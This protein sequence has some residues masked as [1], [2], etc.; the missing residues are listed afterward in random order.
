MTRNNDYSISLWIFYKLQIDHT[1]LV[2]IYLSK[3]PL[4]LQGL[5]QCLALPG[6]HVIISVF[7]H[8]KWALPVLLSPEGTNHFLFCHTIHLF[9]ML[10]WPV[11]TTENPCSSSWPKRPAISCSWQFPGLYPLT[12]SQCLLNLATLAFS[13]VPH[14]CQVFLW[15]RLHY[16]LL[17][18]SK[19][20]LH[21]GT[22]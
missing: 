9:N 16:F 11:I 19:L 5:S 20:F 2:L 7:L 8:C 3:I 6:C 14:I 10:S 4:I 18:P 17:W 13:F 22:S 12:Q 15:G 21:V 1:L